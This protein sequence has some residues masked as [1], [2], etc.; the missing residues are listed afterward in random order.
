MQDI[1]MVQMKKNVSGVVGVTGEGGLQ[2]SE[3][4]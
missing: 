3:R 2:N 1:E 4:I